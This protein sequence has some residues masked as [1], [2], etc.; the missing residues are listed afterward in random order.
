MTAQP[1]CAKSIAMKKELPGCYSVGFSKE[2]IDLQL[3]KIY[4]DAFFINSDILRRFLS[5]I[6]DETLSGHADW[7]KE[8]TIGINVLNKSADFKPQDNGIVRIHAGRLR[9]ALNN[10]YSHLGLNDIIQISI[11]KGGYVPLFT[12]NILAKTQEAGQE[13]QRLSGNNTITQPIPET[14]AI[15]PFRS[16]SSDGLTESLKDGLALQ[17]CNSLMQFDKYTVISYQSVRDICKGSN[18]NE[19]FQLRAA[20]ALK[21]AITGNIQLFQDN[22]R[23][24]VQL[25]ELQSSRQLRSAMYEGQIVAGNIFKLQDE[26]VRFIIAELIT[27]RTQFEKKNKRAAMAVVA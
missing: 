21:Y 3:E 17:L 5:F 13:E 20:M 6:V 14:I 27:N 2:A 1:A 19:L 7:L 24:H 8:Y 12:E 4:K 18:N 11:P 25:I 23:I 22:I 15:L 16:A 10:Y 9:R 26:I